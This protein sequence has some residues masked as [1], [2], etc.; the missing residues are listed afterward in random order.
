MEIKIWNR[1]VA[2][3]NDC[4]FL[5]RVQ[6]RCSKTGIRINTSVLYTHDKDCPFLVLPTKE[7]IE[8]LGFDFVEN[9]NNVLIFNRKIEDELGD[10][11]EVNFSYNNKTTSIEIIFDGFMLI[12]CFPIHNFE[13]LKFI[14]SGF[15]I[16]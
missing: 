13:H 10:S 8:D 7:L 11:I 1:N 3:C 12:Q 2:S 16:I 9:D 4:E 15:G 6:F 5:D 14:L